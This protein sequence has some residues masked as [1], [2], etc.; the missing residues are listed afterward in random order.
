MHDIEWQYLRVSTLVKYQG[1]R[2]YVC[3]KISTNASVFVYSYAVK[4]DKMSVISVSNFQ[5]IATSSNITI[6]LQ[7]NNFTSLPI[8]PDLLA[9]MYKI[10]IFPFTKTLFLS[11]SGLLKGLSPTFIMIFRIVLSV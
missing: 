4:V 10:L 9:R 1:Q 5:S 7:M 11:S 3:L 6:T 2:V 8:V